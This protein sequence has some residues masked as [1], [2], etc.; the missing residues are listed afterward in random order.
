MIEILNI[1]LVITFIYF[2]TLFPF[3]KNFSFK[4]IDF[5]SLTNVDVH[6]LNLIFHMMVLFI[7][8]F[9]PIKIIYLIFLQLI[10]GVTL[11]ISKILFKKLNFLNTYYK[12]DIFLLF[13]ITFIL[14]IDLA[15]NL[16]LGWDSQF[17]W[18]IKALNFY[19]GNSINNLVNF[20]DPEYPH[21][22][23]Y[24]WA[25]FWKVSILNY[26]YTGRIIYLAIYVIS[27]FSLCEIFET[28][29]L[30]KYLISLFIITLSYRYLPFD[31]YQDIVVFSFLTLAS[32]NIFLIIS[33][34][35]T[36]MIYFLMLSANLILLSWIKTEA[37]IYSIFILV[38]LSII[39]KKLNFKLLF[40]FTALLIITIKIFTYNIFEFP[41]ILQGET[42]NKSFYEFDISIIMER[43][44][45][46][47]KYYIKF[48]F[49][50]LLMLIGLLS[51]VYL[52]LFNLNHLIVR[53]LLIFF[54]FNI[55]FI[56]SSHLF[57][58]L[59]NLDYWIT[60]TIP[61]FMLQTTG[62]YIIAIAYI[63][64]IR[65]KKIIY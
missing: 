6:I 56:Y 38:V 65:L 4:K 28:T 29:K 52:S 19:Q 14:S 9:L 62:I 25:Y 27:I 55:G 32:K 10:I 22:G 53:F 34:K 36:N 8:S 60:H 16:N 51:L 48:L 40:L 3:D 33:K 1:I 13:L 64:N 57:M 58:N 37:M 31:G 17:R 59:Q 43:F 46:V 7:A 41:L 47:T 42:Y 44:L 61:R 24:L 2:L 54:L 39:I 23:S 45:I 35:N 30:N 15:S 11:L 26:E 12:V 63:Y 49:N 18:I 20:T 5:K 21:F 50:N